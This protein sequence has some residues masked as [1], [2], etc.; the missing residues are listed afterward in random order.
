[1]NASAAVTSGRATGVIAAFAMPHPPLAVAG[2]GRGKE[3]GASATLAAMRE[4]A[5]RVAALSPDVLVVSSPHATCY[6]DYVHI[7]P[8]EGASGDFSD[9]GDPDDEV[10]VSY[11]AELAQAIGREAARAQ[12][13]AGSQGE[14]SRALDHGTMIPL[15]FI[16]AAGCA[17]PVVR[18]GISGLSPL[19]HYRLGQCVE[20]ACESLSRRAVYVASGDLSHKLAKD[21]PYGFAPEGPAFDRLVCEAFSAADFGA[22]LSIDRGFAERAAECGLRS[23]QIMAGALDGRSVEPE[24]L[25][26]EGPFGV[27][28]GVAAFTPGGPDPARRFGEAWEREARERMERVRAAEDPW[29][30][31]ARASLE[32]WVLR[33]EKIAPPPG[34]PDELAHGRAGAFCSIKKNGELRG[35][36]GTT[37]P[38]RP[39]LAEEVIENAV[40]AGTADPRFPAVTP[41]E[42]GSLVYDVD[43]LD[44]PEEISGPDGLDP[45][46]YGVIVRAE[47]G[48]R[49]LLLPDLD[50]VDTVE[51]QVAIARRKGGIRPGEPVSLQRFTV[52]RHA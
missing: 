39:T 16:Q 35:C 33:R 20:T 46:R 7:S 41:D 21:G 34:L 51:E 44:P 30:A 31:L 52:T 17:C 45:R 14:R 9:F 47:D 19:D 11:D 36:I 48:R 15:T 26:H 50:G 5:R 12:I 32:A 6:L 40:S 28:Y 25:S 3:R 1:M 27:G 24:L 42:L 23:F 10:E 18:M 8:G 2:V 37:Q 29:T 4:A 43:V 49:G 13:P 22:L 38:T